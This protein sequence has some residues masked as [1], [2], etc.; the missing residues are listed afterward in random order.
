MQPLETPK[1][2][3]DRGSQSRS[4][5]TPALERIARGYCG[6]SLGYMVYLLTS[7]LSY[8]YHAPSMALGKPTDDMLTHGHNMGTRLSLSVNT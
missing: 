3:V 4:G 1:L 6:I 5:Q 8:V 2:I 7:C